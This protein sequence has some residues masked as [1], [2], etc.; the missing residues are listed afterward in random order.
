MLYRGNKNYRFTPNFITYN[1]DEFLHT[2][3]HSGSMQ[4][5]KGK[6]TSIKAWCPY[7]I[8]VLNNEEGMHFWQ[9]CRGKQTRVPLYTFYCV[10]VQVYTR[11]WY[12][13]MLQVSL[14]KDKIRSCCVLLR[15]CSFNDIVPVS[16]CR[17]KSRM[18]QICIVRNIATV[19]LL[20][21][22][23]LRLEQL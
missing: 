12:V 15:S 20:T 10:I 13:N 7:S 3:M 2:S 9:L 14:C 11:F 5:I 23:I 8:T 19:C 18:E 1:L 22:V 6:E 16:L 4:H 17:N 21:A